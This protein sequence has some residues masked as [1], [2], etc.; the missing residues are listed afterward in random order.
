MD[1]TDVNNYIKRVEKTEKEVVK[2]TG[3]NIKVGVDLGTAYIV[4]VALDG[5]DNPLACEK[6]AASVLKDG[7]VVDFMGARQIVHELKETI[8]SRIGCELSQCAIAMP[9]GTQSSVRT[10]VYVAESAGFEV[11]R[12]LDEPSAA[13]AIFRISNGV[14]VDIGGGTTGLAILRDGEVVDI[15][16][17][18][19]GGTHL[20]LVLAGNRGI[21][22]DEAEV[23][24]MDYSKHSEIF[25]IV[26]PVLEKMASIVKKNIR[27]ANPEVVY[28]CGG[29]CCLTGIE[30]VFEDL[31]GL[32]VLKPENPFLITPSG[33]AM[34]CVPE[35]DIIEVTA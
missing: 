16:D 7:V 35:P 3:G 5:N 15:A 27:S 2:P 1:F 4:I 20:S 25:P 6:K 11:I 19:T 33:I 22:F 17:E 23:I 29:T 9:A 24:K 12:I 28:L 34:N 10:H 31:L 13:N 21:S 30:K 26:K 32:P 8:E 14:I 18:A